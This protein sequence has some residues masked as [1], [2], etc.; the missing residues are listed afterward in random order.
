MRGERLPHLRYVPPGAGSSPHARG[1]P[2]AD[3]PMTALV[4]FIPACA[5]NAPGWRRSGIPRSVH[6]RMRG[7]RW[8]PGHKPAVRNGSSPHARGTQM[9]TVFLTIVLRFIP[10]CAGNATR[11][12]ATTP[13]R[14]V[15]PRMRGERLFQVN[16]CSSNYGSS[17]HARG[18]HT[19]THVPE[20]D[21]RF[22]PAY[23]GNAG[24]PSGHATS[25]PVH[26]RIRGERWKSTVSRHSRIGSSPH[27]RG[28]HRGRV[29]ERSQSRFI[30][31]YAGNAAA[32]WQGDAHQAVH[33]RI[34]GER[35]S[36]G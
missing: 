35:G 20:D 6:P 5:G 15:H 17:P 11:C 27:T 21:N 28:T 14:T 9:W 8:E 33:P 4:R 2:A 3:D 36:G 13:S 7:E 18:T 12:T 34:R 16:P 10:A 32:G 25:R 23:A 1:T 30:P 22:I 24:A 19:A 29:R 26:P 31:A